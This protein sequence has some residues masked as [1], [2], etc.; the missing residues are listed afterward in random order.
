M[1]LKSGNLGG[2]QS[3]G[4]KHD[5][6]CSR[7]IGYPKGDGSFFVP[8]EDELDAM[9]GDKDRLIKLNTFVPS[10]DVDPLY[11][12]STYVVK[13]EK[14]V[15]DAF[16]L[17]ARRL[18]KLDRIAVGSAVLDKDEV[19]LFLR[20]S[21]KFECLFLEVGI[22]DEQIKRE[23]IAGVQATEPEIAYSRPMIKLAD[24]LIKNTFE[25]PFD[26]EAFEP[27]RWHRLRNLI[28]ANGASPSGKVVKPSNGE[29]ANGAD[30]MS[31]LK[32]TVAQKSRS[33]KAAPKPRKQKV[34]S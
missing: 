8:S 18:A 26:P 10:A 16:W 29:V 31:A 34:A 1:P 23:L 33:K 14:H 32:A 17:L 19:M 22:F 28:V 3:C 4:T 5:N 9:N 6:A 21:P 12:K 7:T 13:P 2:H 24:D 25:E 30:L 11:F 15:A 27:T 20:W